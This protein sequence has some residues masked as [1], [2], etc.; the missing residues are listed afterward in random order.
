MEEEAR[1]ILKAALS[2]PVPEAA[3]IAASIRELVE[4][5]G[6]VE[7]PVLPDEPVRPPLQK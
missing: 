7:L 5:L 1:Q 6:G 2:A 3:N 4:P